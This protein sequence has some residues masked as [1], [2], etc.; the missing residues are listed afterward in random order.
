LIYLSLGAKDIDFKGLYT[1]FTLPAFGDDYNYVFSRF[2][3]LIESK[4]SNVVF[5]ISFSSDT[6]PKDRLFYFFNYF[7]W[8]IVEAG[9]NCDFYK[10][11][12]NE[13]LS[14]NKI[15]LFLKPPDVFIFLSKDPFSSPKSYYSFLLLISLLF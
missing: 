2:W 11:K 5:S 9:A 3:N 1:K 13:F 15:S 6:L 12:S 8:Y 4:S 10:E 7:C 14:F